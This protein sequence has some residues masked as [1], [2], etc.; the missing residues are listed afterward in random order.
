VRLA[1]GVSFFVEGT[2]YGIGEPG[3]PVRFLGSEPQRW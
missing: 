1:P 3:R 2:L